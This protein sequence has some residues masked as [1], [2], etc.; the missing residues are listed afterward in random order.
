MTEFPAPNKPLAF[1]I[2]LA[3]DESKLS[4][5]IEDNG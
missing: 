1:D 5:H 2:R 4:I 3:T